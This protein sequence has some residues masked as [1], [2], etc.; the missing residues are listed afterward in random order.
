MIDGNLSGIFHGTQFDPPHQ[1]S[2][3]A[4]RQFACSTGNAADANHACRVCAI[5]PNWRPASNDRAGSRE[6]P[7]WR[8]RTRPSS[9]RSKLWMRNR[10]SLRLEL[11]RPTTLFSAQ[12]DLTCAQYTEVQAVDTYAKALVAMNQARGGMLERNGMTFDDALSGTITKMP[13][14]PFQRGIHFGR[15]VRIS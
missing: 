9:W 11:P 3:G 14:P 5:K 7:R 1:E 12:R 13:A 6:E 2:R 15:P 8:P 10:R 4:S